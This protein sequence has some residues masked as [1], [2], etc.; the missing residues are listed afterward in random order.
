MDLLSLLVEKQLLPAPEVEAIKEEVRSGE[1]SL[2]DALGKRGITPDAA[3]A[4]LS[5]HYNIPAKVLPQPPVSEGVLGYVP[6][7]SARHYRFVPLSISEGALEVGIVDPDNIEALDALQFISSKVGMPYK[8]FLIS[9]TD[10]NRVIEEYKNLTGEVGEALSE[11]ETSLDTAKE[12]ATA[13]ARGPKVTE[14]EAT[15][16]REDAPVTK[17][18]A[19]VLRYAVEGSASDIHIEPTNGKTRVRFRMD[20]E[21]HTSLELPAKVHPAVVARVKILSAMR[22]DEKRKPQDGRFSATVDRKSVV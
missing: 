13:R 12:E 11:L 6:E 7:E 2:D 4:V 5:E 22:L 15:T 19:T 21:L 10:F 16:I 18:V 1:T 8:L 14:D 9:E 3:L 20:G 17:I